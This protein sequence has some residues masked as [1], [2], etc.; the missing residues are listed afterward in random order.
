[1]TVVVVKDLAGHQTTA[2]YTWFLVGMLVSVLLH[3]V[4]HALVANRFRVRTSKW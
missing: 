4:A 2:T 3:E 1:M